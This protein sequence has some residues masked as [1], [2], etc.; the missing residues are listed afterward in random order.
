MCV[1]MWVYLSRCVCMHTCV[2]EYVYVRAC[3]RT[4]VRACVCKQGGAFWS[5]KMMA[6]VPRTWR[7]R[8]KVRQFMTCGGFTS[9]AFFALIVYR[10]SFFKKIFFTHMHGCTYIHSCTYCAVLMLVIRLVA[11]R[12]VVPLFFFCKVQLGFLRCCPIPQCLNPISLL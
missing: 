1:G 8:T 12:I 4:C 9:A 2:R 3:V 10:V 11:W 6:R 7:A 5:D